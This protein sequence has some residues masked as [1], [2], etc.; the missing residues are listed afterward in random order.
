MD[1]TLARRA[2]AN[3]WA[4]QGEAALQ[5]VNLRGRPTAASLTRPRLVLHTTHDA[6]LLYDFM[7]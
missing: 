2:T 6:V 7:G 4:L 1:V 5:W 3:A